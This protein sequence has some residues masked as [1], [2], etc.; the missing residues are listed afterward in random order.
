MVWN[1]GIIILE[2]CERRGEQR[3]HYIFGETGKNGGG[4]MGV[5]SF[6][7]QMDALFFASP[8]Q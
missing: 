2:H 5:K 4:G 3:W 6:K 8:G 1:L 7:K